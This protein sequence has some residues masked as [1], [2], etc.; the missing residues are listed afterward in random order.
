M[1]EILETLANH[2]LI[3]LASLLLLGGL[4]I[5]N[6]ILGA[7]MSATIGEFDK[8]R[9]GRS[10][11]KA[12]LILFAVCIYYACLELMPILMQYVGIDIPEDL[13]TTIEILFII[14]ASFTKYAKEIFSKL[15][16]LFDVT[17]VEKETVVEVVAPD[18]E[19]VDHQTGGKDGDTDKG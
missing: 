15:L 17:K 19:D 10:I 12:L 2:L 6:M 8:A 4:M 18:V 5:T 11:I 13:I 7:V 14:V 1:I 16:T 3:L 9:F